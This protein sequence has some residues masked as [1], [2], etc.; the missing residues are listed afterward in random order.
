MPN[1]HPSNTLK[2]PRMLPRKDRMTI[3]GKI[4]KAGFIAAFSLLGVAVSQ[5][6]A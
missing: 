6:L 4:S 1:N 5:A 3:A 2:K